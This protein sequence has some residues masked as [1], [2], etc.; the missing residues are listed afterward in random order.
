M[1]A[2]VEPPLM[3]DGVS[4]VARREQHGQSGAKEPDLLCELPSGH[5]ASKDD[6]G[7]QQVDAVCLLHNLNCF[8]TVFSRQNLIA[9]IFEA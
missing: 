7:E 8:V 4:R 5:S 2:G 3:H 9:K 6:V 1:H